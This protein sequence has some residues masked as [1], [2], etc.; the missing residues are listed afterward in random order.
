M[1]ESVSIFDNF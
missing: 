1:G